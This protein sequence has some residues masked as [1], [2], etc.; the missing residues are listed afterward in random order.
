M[1]NL[2]MFCTS[3]E[4]NHYDF[5]KKVGYIPSALGDKDFQK[6]WLRDNTDI[7]ISN[8]NKN[9]AELTFHY[10][11]WK[12]Y[13]SKCDSKWIGFCHYRKFWTKDVY[14]NSEI[15]IEK[16]S[17]I[18]LKEIPE[19][20]DQYEVILGTPFYVNQRKI[21]K[22]LKKGFRT[23]LEKPS[24]LL[25][26]NERTIKFHFD[27]MHGK[28]NLE[29]AIQFL[30]NENREDFYN[31]VNNKVYFHP[32]NMFICRSKNMIN[33]YYQTLFAWLDKCETLFSEKN[34][35]GYDLTRIYAFLAERFTSYWFTKNARYKIMNISFYDLRNDIN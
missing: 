8:K 11:F 29:K 1:K 27:I 10:W 25:N 35:H 30:D 16:L 18:I 17:S 4:P 24:L 31:Y 13:L 26:S 3:M 28:N 22:F 34:L 23:I 7:N 21:M 6:G 5:I 15:N 9:Y 19:E 2:E 12:N 14:K 20:F 32:F 33:L